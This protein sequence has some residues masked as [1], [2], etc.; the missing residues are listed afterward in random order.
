VGI[1][2]TG[3]G[4]FRKKKRVMKKRGKADEMILPTWNQPKLWR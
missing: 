4:F 3:V 1:C 2:V